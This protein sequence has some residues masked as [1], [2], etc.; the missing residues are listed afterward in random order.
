MWYSERGSLETTLLGHTGVVVGM[1]LSGDGLVVATAGLDG[2]LML[3]RI[4]WEP[5]CTLPDSQRSAADG[6]PRAERLH[7]CRGCAESG[8]RVCLEACPAA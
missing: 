5:R 2:T 3:S 8:V 1:A 4:A 7:C 6:Y